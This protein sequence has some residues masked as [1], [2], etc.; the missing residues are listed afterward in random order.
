ML[1]KLRE[2]TH[3]VTL[4]ILTDL[5]DLVLDMIGRCQAYIVQNQA[6]GC[7]AIAANQVNG[8]FR[9]LCYMNRG[10]EIINCINPAITKKAHI[11]QVN[12]IDSSFPGLLCRVERYNKITVEYLRADGDL[13]KESV[14]L[15]GEQA[16]HF[17]QAMDMLDNIIIFDKAIPVVWNKEYPKII[18]KGKCEYCNGTGKTLVEKAEPDEPI[19]WRKCWRCEGKKQIG[20]VDYYIE[21]E[22]VLWFSGMELVDPNPADGTVVGIKYDTKMKAPESKIISL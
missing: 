9:I 15:R 12:A 13:K 11:L 5:K 17:Q 6:D 4:Q 18:R 10:G 8:N 16:M 20:D 19:K 2:P 14:V 1:K 22:N 7:R 3:T 21:G